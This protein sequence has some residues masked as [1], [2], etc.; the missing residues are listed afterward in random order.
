MKTGSIEPQQWWATLAGSPKSETRTPNLAHP[1]AEL[2]SSSRGEAARAEGVACL[3]WWT[4]L[5]AGERAVIRALVRML[6][7]LRRSR[8]PTVSRAGM[9]WERG[10]GCFIKVLL[11]GEY[12]RAKK[13]MG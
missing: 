8:V 7:S 6:R 12:Q 2:A 9:K 3:E 1:K 11:M 10:I 4:R 5:P 13:R